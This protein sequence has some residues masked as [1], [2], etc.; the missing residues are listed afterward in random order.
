MNY[1]VFVNRNKFDIGMINWLITNVSGQG[2]LW[3]VLIGQFEK[4]V[5]YFKNETDSSK[6]K[7]QFGL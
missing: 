1:L 6:F 7:L 2:V 5:V 3:K 4:R